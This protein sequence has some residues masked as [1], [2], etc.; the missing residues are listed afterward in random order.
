[1]D[2]DPQSG[3]LKI[4]GESYPEN[5]LVFFRPI[6]DWI[7]GYLKES[8]KLSLEL[9]LIYMNTTS[10]KCMLELLDILEEAYNNGGDICLSWLYDE[11]NDRALDTAEEFEEDYTMPFKIIARPRKR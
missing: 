6:I 7:S 4:S 8:S 10:V 2:F 3:R 11:D 9:Y 1:V 5:T